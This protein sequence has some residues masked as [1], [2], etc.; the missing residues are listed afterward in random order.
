MKLSIIIPVFNEEKTIE[1]I[2]GRVCTTSL[3]ASWEKEIILVDDGSTDNSK[4]EIQRGKVKF[5]NHNVIIAA[6]KEN[7]GK[8]AAI[9]T[10]LT[11]ATGDYILIQDADLEYDP[12]DYQKLLGSIG[13]DEIIYG[14]RNINRKSRGYFHY[15]LGAG[16]LTR[17]INM[18]FKSKLTDSYTCYKLFPAPLIKSLPLKST[19]FE[20]EAEVTTQILKKG[21]RIKETPINYYPRKFDD[22]KKIRFQDGVKGLWMILKQ[23]FTQ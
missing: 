13:K 22:G 6:H 3:P 7:C 16:M 4:I 10:G 9:R 8:G 17:L 20:F 23:R 21:F 1:A 12:A 18:L 2:L 11:R 5:K 15:A 14:S 19:G